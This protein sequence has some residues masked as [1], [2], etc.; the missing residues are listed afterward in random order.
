MNSRLLLTFVTIT[1][2]VCSITTAQDK[3]EPFP[4]TIQTSRDFK[5][6]LTRL[7][8]DGDFELV[9]GPSN[10]KISQDGQV[11]WYAGNGF[12]GTQKLVFKVKKN[13][14]EE[15]YRFDLTVS[16]S[17]P[18]PV[19][20]ARKPAPTAEEL[21]EW[22]WFPTSIQ[23]SRD[24]SYNVARLL[25]PGQFRLVK[26]PGGL[27]VSNDG[28]IQWYAGNG[29]RGTQKLVIEYKDASGKATTRYF[30]MLVDTSPPRPIQSS[31]IRTPTIGTPK[32][33]TPKVA[34]SRTPTTTVETPSV[35]NPGNTSE[36]AAAP[37]T[38]QGHTVLQFPQPGG[39]V[40]TPD[41]V[42][43]IVSL[44]EQAQ[45]VYIDTLNDKELK[46]V[47]VEFQPMALALQGDTLYA[48]AKGS[49]VIYALDAKSGQANKEI[50]VGREAILNMACH[51]SEG[52]LY[53]TTGKFRVYAIDPASGKANLTKAAGHFIAVDPVA[54]EFVYTGVQPRDRN[55]VIIE[56]TARGEFRIY[57][58]RWGPRSILMKYAVSGTSLKLASA[59]D[60][61]A[62]NGWWMHLTPDG[63]RIM[64][65]GG[66][67]WRPKDEGSG[68]GYITAVFSTGNLEARIGQLPQK[69]NTVFHP[70]LDVGII[71]DY[72]VELIP[73]K[74]KSLVPLPAIPLSESRD[75]FRTVSLLTFGGQGSKVIL[76]N[77]DNIAKQQG[78]HFI[79]LTLSDKDREVLAQAYG[80]RAATPT[81][82]P[83]A[84][85]FTSQPRQLREWSDIT[86]RFSIKATFVTLIG[87]GV[88]LKKS[89]GTTITVPL[90]QLSKED[91]AY[92]NGLK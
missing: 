61:A 53:A 43:M 20:G 52:L 80:K 65:V 46:R 83:G 68:G 1:L 23:T 3:F 50:F 71:N 66:G 60:N 14:K 13:G 7:V 84:N 62:V 25:G 81:S 79:P 10:L 82:R 4:T 73:F 30:K 41:G 72:G 17:P 91:Q 77:G 49:S 74:S 90:A 28:M 88:K 33:D 2:G 45:L 89:D 26:G 54:G 27:K 59:Q 9:S 42:T 58:D 39:W 55:E 48:A 75:Q 35:P 51:P 64:M 47:D 86:G 22:V 32:V 85:P 18:Q 36:N 40:V 19:S 29:F 8:G 16:S 34:T 70:V 92:V 69:L 37:A 31:A 57:F 78:L 6:D 24:F 15:S 87:Q 11:D 12:R 76:W 63:K 38:K 44:P 21:A 5:Y 67:G 56:E